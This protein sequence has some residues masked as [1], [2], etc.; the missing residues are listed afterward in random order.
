M[1]KVSI[2]NNQKAL[3]L[4]LP[5]VRKQVLAIL[6]HEK[7]QCDEIAVNIVDAKT[8]AD[9]HKKFFNDPS[10]TDCITFPIDDKEEPHCFLGEVFICP[11]QALSYCKGSKDPYEETALYLVHSILHL[12]GYDDIKSEDKKIMKKKEK[13]CMKV[14]KDANLV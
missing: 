9:L 13:S 1:V 7:I 14:L 3:K 10:P 5:L 2:Y 4:S 11:E 8:I 12:S 6:K